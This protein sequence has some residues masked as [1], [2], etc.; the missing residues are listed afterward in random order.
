MYQEAAIRKENFDMVN[1]ELANLVNAE[2]QPAKLKGS[3]RAVEKIEFDYKKNASRIK[4]IL[5]ATLVVDTFQQAGVALKEI[6]N[7]HNVLDDGFRNLLDP[8]MKSMDGGYRDIKMNVE[9]AGHIAEIQINVPEFVA[10]KDKHHKLYEESSKILRI[11][12]G[13]ERQFTKAEQARL[14][15]INAEMKPDYDEALAAV[16]NRSNSA[17]SI[18]APL[19]NAESAGKALGSDSSQAAQ[20]PAKP[21]TE[22]KVTGIPSTSR[23]STFLDDF[24]KDTPD[25]T[26][27]QIGAS[28]KRNQ[29]LMD[30]EI[31]VAERIDPQTGERVSEVT[32][33]REILADFEQDK[34]MLERLIGCVK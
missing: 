10:V 20:T 11:A 5:R 18:G 4:D 2:Y 15:E 9:I 33:V 26:L 3:S 28:G 24:I 12:S 21:G 17:L 14:D 1:R 8:Q 25:L 19:R 34:S 16:L 6:R 23:N 13:E 7:V 22:P 27:A 32:T 29:D 30:L 31:P